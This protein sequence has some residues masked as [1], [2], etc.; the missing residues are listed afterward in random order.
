MNR[1]P[2]NFVTKD[3][4][5]GIVTACAILA[6]AVWLTFPLAAYFAHVQR[7]VQGVVAVAVAAVVCWLT[8]TTALLI[9][10]LYS[11]AKSGVT[12][13]FLGVFLRSAVPLLAAILLTNTSRALAEGGVFGAFVVFY[14]LTLVVETVLVVRIINRV[15]GVAK[16]S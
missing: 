13:V 15:H 5:E 16:S 6:A 7:G 12:G 3:Y 10:S 4:P 2:L 9:T 14:L 8:S 11:T 1:R